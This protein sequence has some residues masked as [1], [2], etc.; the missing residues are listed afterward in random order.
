[1]C[2]IRS[3]QASRHWASHQLHENPL[4]ADLVVLAI[5]KGDNPRDGSMGHAANPTQSSNF[6]QRFIFGINGQRHAEQ[7]RAAR[8]L[9]QID[10]VEGAFGV[11][12]DEATILGRE[13]QSSSTDLSNVVELGLPCPARRQVEGGIIPLESVALLMRH[14]DDMARTSKLQPRVKSKKKAEVAFGRLG[15]AALA[16]LAGE[17][18]RYD[19]LNGW[20]CWLSGG[21]GCDRCWLGDDRLGHGCSIPDGES[22]VLAPEKLVLLCNQGRKHVWVV[23]LARNEIRNTPETKVI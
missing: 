7:R 4:K 2:E 21:A 10:L 17:R 6:T 8:A 5:V 15:L 11:E 18:G 23:W 22:R 13:T 1:M 20:I 9:D 14:F 19:R 3:G 12:S 16:P